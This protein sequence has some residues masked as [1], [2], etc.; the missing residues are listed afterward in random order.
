[1]IV[2]LVKCRLLPSSCNTHYRSCQKCSNNNDEDGDD[3][4]VDNDD[5]D[6]DDVYIDNENGCINSNGNSSPSCLFRC[7]F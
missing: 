3:G 2:V 4:V 7:Y 6:N 5:N 1:M